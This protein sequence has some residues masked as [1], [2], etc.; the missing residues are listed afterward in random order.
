MKREKTYVISVSVSPLN[1]CIEYK[2]NRRAAGR[3]A[4]ELGRNPFEGFDLKEF[5]RCH[6]SEKSEGKRGQ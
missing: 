3:Y 4:R 1:Y 6:V 5:V 2:G